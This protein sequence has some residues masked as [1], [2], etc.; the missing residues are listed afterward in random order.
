MKERMPG[1]RALREGMIGYSAGGTHY[2][3]FVSVIGEKYYTGY[4]RVQHDLRPAPG[5]GF[6]H[7]LKPVEFSGLREVKNFKEALHDLVTYGL[8]AKEIEDFRHGKSD[9][10]SY[11]G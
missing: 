2:K 1:E 3:A 9:V 6:R 7:F 11:P 8:N 4:F 5:E 10:L